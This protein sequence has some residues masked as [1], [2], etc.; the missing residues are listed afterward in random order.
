MDGRG[1]ATVIL[2]RVPRSIYSDLIKWF[3]ARLMKK[4]N[5]AAVICARRRSSGRGRRRRQCHCLF[6]CTER[7]WC[8]YKQRGE[9]MALFWETQRTLN[10]AE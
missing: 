7:E 4:A 10:P 9:L 5:G 3:L 8:V 6:P 2:S 1:L